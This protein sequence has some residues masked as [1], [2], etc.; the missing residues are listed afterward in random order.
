MKK[1]L[2]ERE[3]IIDNKIL[4]AEKKFELKTLELE[5]RTRAEL[6][7]INA[8]NEYAVQ[9]ILK[10]TS[11]MQKIAGDMAKHAQCITKLIED[12]KTLAADI[13][14]IYDILDEKEEA[15]QNPV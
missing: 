8:Y 10:L 15:L 2:D 13:E 14:D 11:V 6:E 5:Q 12:V 9:G 1:M 3:K 7:P 4:L